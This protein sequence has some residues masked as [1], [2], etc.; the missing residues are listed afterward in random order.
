MGSGGEG[1]VVKLI[2]ES[3]VCTHVRMGAAIFRETRLAA[4][5]GPPSGVV[6]A[7]WRSYTDLARRPVGAAVARDG[8]G[9]TW[10]RPPLGGP[11]PWA[12]WISEVG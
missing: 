8:N 10:P 7:R 2:G 1:F 5:R 6:G 11:V 3:I 12:A 9:L 4:A